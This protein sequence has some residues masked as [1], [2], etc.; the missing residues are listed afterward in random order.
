MNALAGQHVKGHPRLRLTVDDL[1]P[2]T[3]LLDKKREMLEVQETLE[4]Q[5]RDFALREESLRAREEQLQRKNVLLRQSLFKFNKFLHDNDLKRARAERKAAEERR[6]AAGKEGELVGLRGQLAG[7]LEGAWT[8]FFFFFFSFLFF[9]WA[10]GWPTR[11][12]FV[13]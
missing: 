1:A 5:K 13:G 11:T 8:V 3:R 10:T 4:S 9:R 6:V 12:R 7:L 2:A